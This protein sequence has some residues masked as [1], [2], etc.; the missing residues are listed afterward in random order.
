MKSQVITLCWLPCLAVLFAAS[1]A[2]QAAPGTRGVLVLHQGAIGG[3]VPTRFEDAFMSV[4]GSPDSEQIELY[5][6]SFATSRFPGPEQPRL[7]LDFLRNRY[8]ERNID[9]IVTLGAPPLNLARQARKVLGNPPIVALVASTGEIDSNDNITG[10]QGGLF[11]NG[12][13][14]LALALRPETQSVLVVDGSLDNNGDIQVEVERQMNA[15]R[16]RLG[17]VYLRDLPLSD[18]VSRVA[19]APDRSIVLF[20]RQSMRTRSQ[21]VSQIEA[22]GQVVNA[23]RVPVFS[24]TEAYVGRGILGG[25]VWNAEVDGRRMAEM[26]TLLANGATVRDV[27]AGTATYTTMLDWRQLQRWNVPES[28]IPA[29]AVV[30]FR[31]QSLFGQYR[32]YV[33]GGLLIFGAQLGLIVGLLVQR[34]QRR[35]AEEESRTNAERYRSVV[36]TQGELIC[37]FLPDTTLTFVNDAYCR[38]W[39]KT[40]GELIGRKFI[41]LVPP[42]SRQAVLDRI[43]RVS[44]GV[45]SLDH[46]VLLADGSVG[47]HHW[48][49]HAILDDHGHLLEYQG[50]GRDISDRKRAEEAVEQLEARNSAILH[51]IPD[52]MFLLSRDGVYLDYYA[53]DSSRLM[54]DPSQFLGRHM[55]E[56]LPPA[57]AAACEGAFRRLTDQETPVIAEYALSM[58]GGEHHY[59]ARIV[60]CRDDQVLAV[61]RDITDRKRA[62]RALHETQSDLSRVS[63]LSTLGEFAASLAHEVRQPLTAIIMNARASLQWLSSSTPDLAQVRDALLDVIGEGQRA[64]GIIDRN[65]ELFKHHTVRKELLDINQVIR[66]SAVLAKERIQMNRVTLVTSLPQNLPP[67][68]GDRLE[69]QQVLLNLISNGIDAMEGID[70]SARVLAISTSVGRDGMLKVAVSDTGVGLQDVDTKR[71]FTLLYT[72]KPK[73]TGV[74]LSI[75]RAIVEAHGGELRAAPNRSGGATFSFTLPPASRPE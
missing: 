25:L 4:M 18:V 13:I 63:R 37:R 75:S 31:P 1:L 50:V 21:Q 69:L 16:Q 12:T 36:D 70:V 39:N 10:L 24:G 40:R 6:E 32:G 8:A 71:M 54:L 27:P 64:D 2:A 45:D 38:F 3:P 60:P 68:K 22:L 42:S 29:D 62:E 72:T 7:V 19:A 56:V 59:E 30:R 17:L 48:I 9:A 67:A 74:G 66:E 44:S 11:I 26:A 52:S 46:P 55:R 20:I 41:E 49:Y 23:S 58:P 33:V 43:G 35:R 47:W 61:V 65:R 57:A 34:A 73:G 51:A 15:R 28:R 14:D 53:P 5:D